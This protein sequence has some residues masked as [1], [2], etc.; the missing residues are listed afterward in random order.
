MRVVVAVSAPHGEALARELGLEGLEVVAR[1]APEDVAR[2]AADPTS[3]VREALGGCEA[4]VL[5][6]A[7]GVLTADVVAMCDRMGVRIL[8]LATSPGE[9]R[10]AGGFGLAPAL[11][12]AADAAVV[13]EALRDEPVPGNSGASR[14]GRV[15]ACWGPHGAPGRSTIAA[16]LAAARAIGGRRAALVD[17]DA[18][19]PSIAQA[20]GLP[21]DAPGFPAACR[22]VDYGVLDAH[23]LTRLSAPIDVAGAHLDVLTGINRPARWPELTGDRVSGVLEAG[24]AWVEEQIVDVAA[25]VERDEEIVSDL[26]GPRR[27]QATIAALEAA[28]VVVAI[29]AAD[30]IGLARFVRGAAEVREIAPD[31]RLAIVVN[32]MRTGAVGLDARAQVRRALGQLAGADEVTFLPADPAAADRALF[33]GAPV[34][35][36]RRRA[37]LGRA[38]A[39]L[40]ATL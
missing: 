23:E 2:G 20:L 5:E 34:L 32:R 25:S 26:D 1:V 31:A 18:H 6:A 35:P 33:D 10:H 39:A 15:I 8:P 9:V 37:G 29:A 11:D 36:A 22:Q 13:V 38:V 7:R 28:D 14:R 4:I 40:A 24:R 3:L 30:P 16:G 19:A 27:N 17:A 21:D 12:I